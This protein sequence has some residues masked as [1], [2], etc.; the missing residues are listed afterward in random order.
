MPFPTKAALL[1]LGV[2][3]SAGLGLV[4][5]GGSDAPSVPVASVDVASAQ[6]APVNSTLLDFPLPGGG[7]LPVRGPVCY[8]DT[9][10]DDVIVHPSENTQTDCFAFVNGGRDLLD[11]ARRTEQ[12]PVYVRVRGTLDSYQ[13][14]VFGQGTSVV[15]VDGATNFRLS[16]PSGGSVVL[17]L[18]EMTTVDIQLRQ[19]GDDVLIDTGR[20]T[21]TLVRQAL[22]GSQGLVSHIVLRG[23]EIVERSQ[24]QVQS[25]IGQGTP[26]DDLIRDT[27]EDDVIYPGLGNDTITLL[28]GRNRVHYE[29][30]NDRINSSGDRPSSNT[31][32]ISYPRSGVRVRASDDGRDI[33]IDTPVGRVRLELQL[34]FPQGDKRVPVQGVVFQDGPVTE[35]ELR[36]AAL[37][38]QVDNETMDADD[39]ERQRLRQ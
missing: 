23:G 35:A 17:A 12:E 8:E 6:Q 34:F 11:V 20:G 3:V 19:Q 2:G 29:G 9:R 25:V 4:V 27:D 36:S 28:G 26:G 1:V 13:S 5:F 24:I 38:Y 22:P 7:S 31:L 37:S 10:G 32:F 39:V 21:I 18:P 33:W 30:G 14:L 16:S 15:E